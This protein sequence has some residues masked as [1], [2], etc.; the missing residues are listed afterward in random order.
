[1]FKNDFDEIEFV[2][3]QFYDKNDIV[4]VFFFDKF[5]I[6]IPYQKKL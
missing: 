1:M 3:N 4:Y 5:G 2:A 6:F